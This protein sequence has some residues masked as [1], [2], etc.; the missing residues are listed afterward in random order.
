MSDANRDQL[1]AP[2]NGAK[3]RRTPM[4][5]PTKPPDQGGASAEEERF[6]ITLDKETLDQVEFLAELWNAIDAARKVKRYRKWVASNVCPTL[7]RA[8]VAGVLEE[9]GGFPE[10]KQEREAVIAKAVAEV[11]R[12]MKK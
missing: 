6:S 11:L 1:S 8:S 7:I 2:F 10:S 3:V 12:E 9:M 5:N 4:P